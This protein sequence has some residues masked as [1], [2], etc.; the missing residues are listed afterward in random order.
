MRLLFDENLSVRLIRILATTYPES[1]H[2]ELLGLRGASDT[3]LW[4]MAKADGFILV[5]KDDD[6]RQR[7]LLLGHPPKVVWLAIGN[8]STQM[9]ADL[10]TRSVQQ[11][12]AFREDPQASL[13]ILR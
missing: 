9:I 12:A 6:F 10:L 1:S 8:T 11:I 4:Q 7:S 5:S 2:P 3:A 13:L